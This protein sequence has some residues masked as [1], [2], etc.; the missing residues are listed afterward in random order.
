[1]STSPSELHIT[2]RGIPAPQ[3]SKKGIAIKKGGKHTGKVALIESAG[4]KVKS[5]RQDVRDAAIAAAE[6]TGWQAPRGPI[7]VDIICYLTRPKGHYRTG[8]YA[9]LL[10]DAAPTFHTTKPDKDKLER[11]TNDALTSSGV[12]IDDSNIVGGSTWKQF[13]DT[14]TPGAHIIIRDLQEHTA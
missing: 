11:A 1:M 6:E 14:R 4:D 12:I 2:V 5:W 9:D 13:A 7:A 3:G 8:R 10:R